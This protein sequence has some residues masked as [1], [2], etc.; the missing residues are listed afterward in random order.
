LDAV[1]VGPK[2]DFE[3]FVF[4]GCRSIVDIDGM[5]NVGGKRK[6]F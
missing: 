1:I 3:F 4:F 5:A 6:F 2:K